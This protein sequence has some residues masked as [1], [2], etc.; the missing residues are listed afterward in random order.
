MCIILSA[1]KY[2]FQNTI[3]R[4]ENGLMILVVSIKQPDNVIEK[5]APKYSEDGP[6]HSSYTCMIWRQSY[7]QNANIE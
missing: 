2:Q 1:E 7:K 3:L 4:A 6:K 5:N